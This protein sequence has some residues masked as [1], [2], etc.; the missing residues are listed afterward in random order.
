MRFLIL[1][2]SPLIFFNCAR[3]ETVVYKYPKLKN[4]KSE[5]THHGISYV[6]NFENLENLKDP[7]VKSWYHSQDS[8]AESYFLNNPNYNRVYKKYEKLESKEVDPAYNL[9]YNESGSIYFL[10]PTEEEEDYALFQKNN[11]T[12]SPNLLFD[13]QDYKDGSYSIEY[14][15]PSYNGEYVAIA[16]GKPDFFF[17]DIIILNSRQKKIVGEPILNTKPNKAGGIIWTPDNKN[18][19]FISYPNVKEENDRNSSTVMLTVGKNK[20]IVIYAD[21][22]NDISLFEENYPVPVIRSEK[23]NYVFLYE[24]NA[25][26]FWDCYYVDIKNLQSQNFKWRKLYSSKDSIFHDW[27]TERNNEYFY[28]R[29]KGNNVELCKVNLDNPNFKNPKLLAKG[30]GESQL[31][32]F[33]V[34]KD[35]L[36]YTITTNGVKTSLFRLREEGKDE[37]IK[38]PISAG[39]ITFDFRSPY[40]NDL[41]ISV[42]GWTSN[43]K[44][45]F[46]NSDDEFEFIELGMWPDY[47]EFNNLISEMIEVESHDGTRVPL[48]IIRRKDHQMNAESMGIITAYGAYGMSETPWF[49]SPIADFVNQGNIFAVAHVRGGGEKGPLWHASGMKDKKE[50]SWKDLIACSEYLI[51][52][53]YIHPKKLG[54]NV[55]SAGGITGGM[56]INERPDLFGVFTGFIPSLNSLRTEYLEDFDDTD[57]SYEFGSIKEK[58]SYMDLL[59][60][61]PVT[62]LSIEKD[63]PSTLLILGYRD[64]LIPPSDSG[65]YIAT[66]QSFNPSNNKPYLLDVNFEAEHEMNWLDDYA[67]MLFFTIT[68]LSKRN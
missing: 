29:S 27:G 62:N 60:M 26:D 22:L 41:W 30:E 11:Y 10:S 39:E 4:T 12:S 46:L 53:N 20:P 59:K 51:K 40:K 54:L 37:L 36:Y 58:Q 66:L 65:K 7:E 64:Y 52:K 49:H 48:S 56:A 38:T 57:N 2:L 15:K 25:S 43:Q 13:P 32:G 47:P 23:S 19:L 34:L 42:S 3:Q 9:I 6:N 35:N 63:Y 17:N 8:V 44:D 50:N 1:F 24:G 67:R 68:E 18:V 5:V 33:K 16:M 61:D 45:Y 14:Y 21:G 31:S 55:N 28:K